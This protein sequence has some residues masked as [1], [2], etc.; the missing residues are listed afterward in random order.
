MHETTARLYEAVKITSGVE[1]PTAVSRLL[2]ISI[3]S[4]GM[5]NDRGVSLEGMFEAQRLLGV[6]AIWLRHGTGP[7][8][9]GEADSLER[10]GGGLADALKLTCE[11]AREVQLLSVYRLSN[12]DNRRTIENAVDLARK[13]LDLL[14]WLN[15]S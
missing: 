3:Q 11:T 14:R 7:M 13:D 5:W 1:S 10:N 4:L 2:N 15:Q 12:Q 9:I 8:M 6:N